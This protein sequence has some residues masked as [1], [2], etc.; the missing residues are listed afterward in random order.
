MSLVLQAAGLADDARQVADG[1][2]VDE[3]VGDG[4]VE[5]RAGA[6]EVVPFDADAVGLELLFE[7]ALDLQLVKLIMKLTENCGV[8]F[9]NCLY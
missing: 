4:L 5:G 6:L 8:N 2:H 3:P 9:I 7:R 1:E